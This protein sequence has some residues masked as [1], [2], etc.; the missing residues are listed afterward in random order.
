[1]RSKRKITTTRGERK[2]R[3]INVDFTRRQKKSTDV[4][5][6]TYKKG[7]NLQSHRENYGMK[8]KKNPELRDVKKN[9]L[10]E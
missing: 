6:N 8:G 9:K 5:N 1:M 3:N 2:K 10:Q 7:L 4:K